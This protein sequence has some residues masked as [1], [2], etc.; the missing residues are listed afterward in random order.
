[1]EKKK[2]FA[3]LILCLA[4]SA[5]G[6]RAEPP[7]EDTPPDVEEEMGPPEGGPMDFEHGGFRKG[8]SKDREEKMERK[9][10]QIFKELGLTPEQKKQLTEHRKIHR[11]QARQLQK[12]LKEKRKILKQELEKSDFNEARVKEAHAQMKEIQNKLTDHRLEG[13]LKVRQ[14]MTAEQFKKFQELT[15]NKRKAGGR[16]FQKNKG[17]Q[18]KGRFKQNE[19]EEQPE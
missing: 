9:H 8:S 11:E 2:L 19:S 15:R 18:G 14:I 3:G 7:Q 16:G 17:R 1:M 13:I 6:G 10:E 4:L 12:T 5:A